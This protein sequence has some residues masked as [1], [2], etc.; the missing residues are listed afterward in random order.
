MQVSQYVIYR[1]LQYFPSG[2]QNTKQFVI[3]KNTCYIH[4]REYLSCNTQCITHRIKATTARCRYNAVHFSNIFTID[5][6]CF[7]YRFSLCLIFC[8]SFAHVVFNILLYR[9]ALLR[10]STV[11]Y[12]PVW[13]C[14]AVG[15]TVYPIKQE[16]GF[17]E[18]RLLWLYNLVLGGVSKTLMSS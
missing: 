6:G 18:C 9:T 12:S 13:L 8:L 3:F 11:C 17:A 10:H 2:R 14:A 4:S 1:Q 15:V 16:H 5:I 7:F